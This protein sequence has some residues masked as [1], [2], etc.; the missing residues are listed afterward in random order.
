MDVTV[1]GKEVGQ[2]RSRSVSVQQLAI[3]VSAEPASVPV[4]RHFAVAALPFL[5]VTVDVDIVALLTTELT[6]NAVDLG[7]GEITVTVHGAPECLRVEVRDYGYGMPELLHPEPSDLGGGRGLL[8]VDHLANRWGID[9]FLPGKIVW[10]ELDLL[11][12][13]ASSPSVPRGS[14]VRPG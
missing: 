9:Q 5:G 3:T 7:A 12:A 10:F 13:E 4:V 1:G 11:G 2:Q 14:T 8:I 6:A